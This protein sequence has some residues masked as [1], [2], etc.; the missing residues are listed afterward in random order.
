MRWSD[1]E[2]VLLATYGLLA[3]RD[4]VSSDEVIA[5]LDPA[6]VNAFAPGRALRY[7]LDNG[8]IEGVTL[9]GQ[10]MPEGIR[11]TEKGLQA[12]SGWPVAGESQLFVS[13]FVEALTQ[14]INDSETA[15]DERG[16]LKRLRDAT[17]DVG[18][19]LVAEIIARMAE[20]K[21]L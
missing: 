8:Y 21:G 20:H 16:K 17:E 3:D 5:A 2:P 6:P 9:L 15:E 10:E 13:G 14:R 12:A 18:V 19:R 7:L 11:P 1:V 4:M